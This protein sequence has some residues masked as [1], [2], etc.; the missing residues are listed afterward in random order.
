[1]FKQ[2]CYHLSNN[3]FDLSDLYIVLSDFYVDLSYLH[4]D[5]SFIHLLYSMQRVAE[6]IMLLTR[7]SVS[8]FVRQS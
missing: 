1:M 2:I 3:N 6:D 4:V 5:L 7:P 8:Q